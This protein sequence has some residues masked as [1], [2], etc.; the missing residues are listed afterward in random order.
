MAERKH[1]IAM[2]ERNNLKNKEYY[3]AEHFGGLFTTKDIGKAFIITEES[4]DYVQEYLKE[5]YPDYLNQIETYE[6]I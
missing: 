3:L 1:V 6:K 5:N 4:K 2:I